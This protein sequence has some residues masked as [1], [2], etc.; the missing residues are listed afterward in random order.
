MSI[1]K[2]T[3]VDEKKSEEKEEKASDEKRL[4]L[5]RQLGCLYIFFCQSCS[6]DVCFWSCHIY[7]YRQLDVYVQNI[8]KYVCTLMILHYA[9]N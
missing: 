6:S 8:S 5:N 9:V 2:P 4:N 1:V 3:K 7:T